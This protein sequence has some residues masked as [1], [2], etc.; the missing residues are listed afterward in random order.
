MNSMRLWRIVALIIAFFFHATA[1]A[2][3]TLEG[4][5]WWHHFY[6]GLTSGYGST[7]W[8]QITP[9]RNN[10]INAMLLSTPIHAEEGGFTV[11]ALIGYEILP[12]FALELTYMRFPDATVFFSPLSL[13]TFDHNGMTQFTTRTD[14]FIL[15][16]KFMVKIPRTKLHVFS[17]VGPALLHRF[18]IIEN[19]YRASPAFTAGFNYPLSAHVT[20]EISFDYVAGYGE[21]ELD[22]VQDYMP[23]LYAGMFTVTYKL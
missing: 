5:S 1:A 12:E 20:A 3:N 16:G 4:V 7:T 22:P 17:S 2:T 8:N 23:F 19:R 18:D 21:S 6:V 10:Q 14:V 13:F 11:G 15:V 9:S